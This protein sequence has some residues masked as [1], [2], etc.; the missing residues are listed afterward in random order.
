[1]IARPSFRPLRGFLQRGLLE[2]SVA[3]RLGW[4]SVAVILLWLAICWALS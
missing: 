2:Q 1:V 3:E 4:V